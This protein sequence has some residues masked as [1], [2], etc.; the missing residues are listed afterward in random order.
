MNKFLLSSKTPKIAVHAIYNE[1]LTII[2]SLMIIHTN[3]QFNIIKVSSSKFKH[4]K[5]RLLLWESI[6]FSLHPII[7]GQKNCHIMPYIYLTLKSW[8]FLPY[9]PHNLL[10]SPY[11]FFILFSAWVTLSFISNSLLAHLS[12]IH[13]NLYT[14]YY[15]YLL[16]FDAHIYLI[17]TH[18]NIT[19]PEFCCVVTAN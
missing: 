14:F 7:P 15:L 11:I 2:Y 18:I 3:I 12:S 4:W 9:H 13:S 1:A 10:T 19:A 5:L 17:N 8:P 16:C 6:K